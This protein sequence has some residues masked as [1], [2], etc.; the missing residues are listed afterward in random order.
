M[1]TKDLGPI[2]IADMG[3]T[4]PHFW[5]LATVGTLHLALTALVLSL[6]EP[7]FEPRVLE[8]VEIV[9]LNDGS[10]PA[11]VAP[12]P[13]PAPLPETNAAPNLAATPPDQTT[14]APLPSPLPTSSKAETRQQETAL[15][16]RPMVQDTSP[17]QVAEPVTPASDE[18]APIPFE[19]I[20]APPANPVTLAPARPV[21][22]R[23][24]AQRLK[25]EAGQ[26]ATRTQPNVQAN[27]DLRLPDPVEAEVDE[28]FRPAPVPDLAPPPAYA[29]PAPA[30][31]PLVPRAS[32][33]PIRLPRNAAPLPNV[34]VP[35][36]RS[37]D[38]KL[39]E[40]AVERAASGGSGAANGAASG[41]ANG[42]NSAGGSG[43]GAAAAT[44]GV[45]SLSGGMIAGGAPATANGVAS[46]ASG[47]QPS[48]TGVLPRRPG[49]AGVKQ[50]FPTG[51][52]DSVLSR[53]ARTSECAQINR[54]RDAKCPTWDPIE[55]RSPR[56]AQPIPV[57]VPKDA[58]PARF[59]PG[60][61]PLP[62]CKPG[63]P[64]AQFG[65]SC[66]PR[67]DGPGIPKP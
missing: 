51:V 25:I 52:G 30:R 49:G 18:P 11:A 62:L 60:T 65:L 15:P 53:M 19:P 33:D 54:P 46:G 20:P 28:P 56:Q 22:V 50:E 5:T 9:T 31:A 40:P 38:L 29:L 26:L 61:N 47:G 41:A 1:K 17:V 24:D 45:T 14:P 12:P 13:T 42:A 36:I 23:P 2:V 64:Q 66:L 63:T 55:G 4:R 8:T 43:A 37:S 58:A 44:G 34:Q 6:P 67:D 48:G 3:H 35:Q 32:T 39:P 57:P 16:P 7:A 10:T 21:L 59:A 27:P